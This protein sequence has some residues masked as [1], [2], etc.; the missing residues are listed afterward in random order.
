MLDKIKRVLTNASGETIGFSIYSVE[1]EFPNLSS[2]NKKI[3]DIR[4]DGFRLTNRNPIQIADPFV[5]VVNGDKYCFFETKSPGKPG[6]ICVLKFNDSGHFTVY[7]C[8]L[9]IA[10]HVSF[11]FLFKDKL[12]D[13]IYLIPETAAEREV[14]IYE[15]VVFPTIW[16]K[17][18]VLLTGNYVD[19]H[20]FEYGHVYYLFTTEK[21]AT[22][23]PNYFNYQLQLYTSNQLLGN[24]FP[25]P[26]N[27][28]SIGRKFA[29]SAGGIIVSGNTMFRV[30]QDCAHSYG[31]ELMVMKI[32]RLTPQEYEEELV[33]ERWINRTFS[34]VTGG[35]HVSQAISG[36]QHYLAVDFN[37]AD[38][39]FQRFINPFLK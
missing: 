3:V 1:G 14:A 16:H 10:S 5:I 33:V 4:P 24:Y 9:Q 21:I 28:I 38:S 8:D 20:V 19:S 30:A 6:E 23:K 32:L 35:H 36:E 39:Y 2:I 31:R 13:K 22:E 27:P 17:K 26:R 29:R 12:S 15:S 37:Y 11:P 25:H 34:H 7:S 18:K